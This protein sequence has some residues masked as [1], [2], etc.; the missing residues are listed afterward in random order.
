MIDPVQFRKIIAL[1]LKIIIVI[2]LVSAFGEGVGGNWTRFAG[3]L[4]IAGF[5]YLTWDRL[6]FA[7]AERKQISR[8]KIE[9]SS[10]HIKLWD[11]LAF[12]LLWS[13]E[14]YADIPHDRKRLI[15]ISYTLIAFG[16]VAAFFHIGS[17][18]MMVVIVGG[19]ILGAVNL[20][21]WVV[22]LEREQRESLQTELTL[23]HDVQISLMPKEQPSIPGFDI[24]GMS[25]PA[26]EVGGDHFDYAFTGGGNDTFAISVVDVSGKGM[27]AA[28][29]AVF[30]SG[31]YSSEVKR[32][33]SPGEILT[34]LNRSIF[35]HTKRGQFVSFLLG[36]INLPGKTLC[37]ANAGQTKPMLFSSKGTESMNSVGVMF[38]L[39]MKEDS[40]YD[41]RTVQLQAGDIILLL[42]DGIT[43]AMNTQKEMFGVENLEKCLQQIN[44]PVMTAQQILSQITACVRR[45]S[46]GSPQH[47]DMTLVVV[48]VL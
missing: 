42:T 47:D 29:S 46:N 40:T 7:V 26:Q 32:S 28:M 15:V 41:E 4:I 33:N 48:K 11:A 8:Q 3:D 30:T 10:D 34:R 19:L 20:L 22:S 43:E 18:L 25:L 23:A 37:F 35:A 39:G 21:A 9:H 36:V 17:T 2:E 16:V 44:L 12:S 5:L 31:A 27:Q 38:P 6:K 24:A 14:I 1:A 45:F 13:D